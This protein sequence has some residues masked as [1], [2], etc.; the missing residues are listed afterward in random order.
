MSDLKRLVLDVLKPHHPSIV[1]LA[2]NLS[3]VEGVYGVNC[4]VEEVDHATMNIKITVEGS[5]INFEA[6]SDVIS[7]S[8]AV[9]HSIDSVSAG[10]KL[11]E[12][13]ETPQD[14]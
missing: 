8:G 11:V 9:I 4:S 12:E 5:A 6:V 1:E 3:V 2:E 7:E 13:V 14:R 10:K